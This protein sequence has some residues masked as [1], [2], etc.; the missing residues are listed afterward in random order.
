MKRSLKVCLAALIVSGSLTGA[1]CRAENWAD[2]QYVAEEI[3]VGNEKAFQKLGDL[4]GSGQA[5]CVPALI[6]A[7][8]QNLNRDRVLETLIEYADPRS[9]DLLVE[10]L[11]GDFDDRAAMAA[12]ALAAMGDEAS[13]A[14]IAE[15]LL[16]TSD[17]QQFPEFFSALKQLPAAGAADA[18]ARILEVRAERVGGSTTVR[19]GC[20]ILGAAPNP[21][22][23]TLRALSFSLVNIV[24]TDG[25]GGDSFDPCEIALLGHGDAAVPALTEMFNGRY[26][27][28]NNLLRELN[29]H[30]IGAQR[31]AAAALSDLHSDAAVASLTAWL[32][33]PHQ[34]PMEELAMMDVSRQQE[35]FQLSGQTFEA[36][37]RGLGHRHSA[38]DMAVLRRLEAIEAPE[39]LLVNFQSWFPLSIA[40]E[41]SLRS[42]VYEQLGLHGNATDRE[43]MWMRAST[44]AVANG[45]A[46]VASSLRAEIV[47]WLGRRAAPEDLARYDALLAE[48]ALTTPI[49]GQ[50]SLISR[51]P[52]FLVPSVCG[53]DVNCLI[54]LIDNQESVLADQVFQN[55]FTSITTAAEVPPV[56]DPAEGSAQAL[57]EEGLRRQRERAAATVESFRS[58][59]NAA[60][61]EAAILQLGLRFGSD[62]TAQAKL[63]D[64]ISATDVSQRKTAAYVFAAMETLPAEFAARVDAFVAS[65]GTSSNQ[66]ARD[67]LYRLRAIRIVRGQ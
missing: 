47:L 49:E 59:L 38:A 57:I 43:L 32:Q 22:E 48:V 67:A 9:R 64:L 52:Y 17:R 2:P 50:T 1:G 26:E 12:R 35:W 8:E 5:A 66:A 19:D 3:L 65:E 61:R 37:V 46:L 60:T 39:S 16:R 7:Y 58:E 33:T 62:P 20:Q 13:A 45:N 55:L 25:Q 29:F 6:Q 18:V 27:A 21:S 28:A 31:R 4:D 51:R 30:P 42:F 23:S 54:G 34:A 14:L 36:A 10:I 40:A 44:A 63:L 11:N 41:S 15:R 24:P 53:N 56:V